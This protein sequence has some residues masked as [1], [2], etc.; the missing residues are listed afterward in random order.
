LGAANGLCAS[1][2]LTESRTHVDQKSIDCK[3]MLPT[4]S[5]GNLWRT[6]PGVAR[7]VA[8]LFLMSIV[9]YGLS[10]V[11]ILYTTR[12]FAWT[13][14]ENGLLL[15]AMGVCSAVSKFSVTPTFVS[16]LGERRIIVGGLALQIAAFAFAIFT[17]TGQQ[18]CAAMTVYSLGAIAEPA[19][20]AAASRMVAKSYQGQLQGLGRST[21]ALAGV[22]APMIFAATYAEAIGFSRSSDIA[23]LA[24]APAVVAL[25]VAMMLLASAPDNPIDVGN[26]L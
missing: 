8:I 18:F 22:V 19:L 16:L 11:I 4:Y 20:F 10:A 6:Y 15:A 24:L 23:N 26:G 3:K 7:Y 17:K 21:D 2:L 5:W 13:V 25:L 12:R 1:S 14:T 9:V